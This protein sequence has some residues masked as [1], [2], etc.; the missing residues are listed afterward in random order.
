MKDLNKR[1]ILKTF[2]FCIGATILIISTAFP[3]FL[4]LGILF[5]FTY[6]KLWNEI[7]WGKKRQD[8]LVIWFTGLSGS[9]KS[10]LSNLIQKR[11]E[12]ANHPVQILDGDELRT[13]INSDLGFSK[14][15]RDENIKRISYIAKLLADNGVIV[16][17]AAISPYREARQKAR[18]LIGTNRFFEVYTECPIADL[19]KRDPKGLY[20]KA[21][22]GE[23]KNFTGV[24]DP[25]EAPETPECVIHTNNKSDIM[26]NTVTIIHKL[27]RYLT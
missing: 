17:T 20:K 4:M 6:E 19:A 8:G 5:Y 1:T 14:K 26:D 24:S 11:P 15:D 10:A 25:Y 12:L 27:E 21:M 3:I 16:I 7:S 13:Y 23:I 9:G 18:D 2:L 22:A